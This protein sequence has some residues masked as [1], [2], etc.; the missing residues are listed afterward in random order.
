MDSDWAAGMHGSKRAQAAVSH[1]ASNTQAPIQ[2]KPE[3]KGKF[4]QYAHSKGQSVQAAARSI[5][6]NP[7]APP[8]RKKQ[9]NFARN[10]ANW[11]H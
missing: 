10:A 4:T 5:L 11:H 7:S 1:A 6:A 2:I 8:A 9:A 3:N